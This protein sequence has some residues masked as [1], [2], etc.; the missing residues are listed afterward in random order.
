MSESHFQQRS[1]VDPWLPITLALGV[2]G[3]GAW[4]GREEWVDAEGSTPV[5]LGGLAPG[6]Q[7]DEAEAYDRM[8]DFLEFDRGRLGVQVE[9]PDPVAAESRIPTIMVRKSSVEGLSLKS[10]RTR[11]RFLTK[12]QRQS[13]HSVLA[14]SG[15]DH[16]WRRLV[17]HSSRSDSGNAAL[18]R[19]YHLQVNPKL[20]QGAYHFVIGNGS[21]SA[22]G[23]I[24][25]GQRWREQLPG[26]A[27]RVEA[28]NEAS[29]SVCLIGEFTESGPTVAQWRALDELMAYLRAQLGPISLV[30]HRQVESTAEACPGPGFDTRLL[31]QLSERTLSL[32]AR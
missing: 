11:W 31:Q 17:V 3:V 19:A 29:L 5:L 7:A 1:P 20:K 16:R 4:L 12:A 30:S 10:K 22:D 26:A 18:L 9:I 15:P 21:H 32:D 28:L 14:R 24:S 25:I 6:V 13:I 27:M 23:E 2:L 8:S